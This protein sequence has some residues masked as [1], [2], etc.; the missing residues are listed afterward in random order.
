[1]IRLPPRYTRTATLF[2]YTT[3]FRSQQ[4]D[5]VPAP[6]HHREVPQV[7]P[8]DRSHHRHGLAARAPPAEA[9]RHP[10]A[11]L[12]DRVVLAAELVAGRAR[13]GAR[14]AGHRVVSVSRLAT[15][16]SRCSDRQST[17]LNSSHSCASR[18]PDSDLTKTLIIAQ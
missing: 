8:Q 6:A 10:G 7:R 18:L 5:V 4:A 12:G 3:L 17:R 14:R 13:R 1:M 15:N 11:Q 2:P 9:D 16:E